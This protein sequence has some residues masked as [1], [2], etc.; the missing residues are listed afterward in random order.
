[1]TKRTRFLLAFLLGML[2][3][4]T[5]CKLA[6][7]TILGV[8]FSP[9]WMFVEDLRKEGKKFDIPDA[10]NLS[11]DTVVYFTGLREIYAPMGQAITIV[12]EDSTEFEKLERVAKD[13]SQS[14]QFRMFDQDGQEIFKMVGCYVPPFPMTWNIDECLDQFPPLTEIESLQSHH[15]DLSWLLSRSTSVDG[16]KLQLADLPE[17]DYY[18]VVIWNDW[19]PKAS[20]IL[21]R[22][23]KRYVKE[24]QESGET[25]HLLYICTHNGFMWQMMDEETKIEVKEAYEEYD[26]E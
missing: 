17:A 16:N 12:D 6:Y 21:I 26:S 7:I 15:F 10:Y 11:L 14:T 18:A 20:R 23:A 25:V 9:E 24:A 13:D 5:S 3:S 19:F 2:L 1:M 8:N 22:Q 4:L